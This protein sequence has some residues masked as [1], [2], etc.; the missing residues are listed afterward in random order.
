M[1]RTDVFDRFSKKS[2][3]ASSKFKIH[4]AEIG[5]SYLETS[6]MSTVHCALFKIAAAG[7]FEEDERLLFENR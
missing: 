6:S 1:E 7:I 2:L 3:S 5:A 4:T